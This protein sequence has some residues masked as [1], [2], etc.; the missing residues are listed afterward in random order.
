MTRCNKGGTYDVLFNDGETFSHR[1]S[2]NQAPAVG[3]FSSE[4][5]SL[6]SRAIASRSKRES[7]RKVVARGV[8]IRRSSG[9]RRQ[10]CFGQKGTSSHDAVGKG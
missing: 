9:R 1:H 4:E 10:H 8:K 5:K 6:A 7:N 2:L 3:I